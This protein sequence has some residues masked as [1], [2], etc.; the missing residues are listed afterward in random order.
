[1]FLAVGLTVYRSL[2]VMCGEGAW[3]NE[4]SNLGWE[5]NTNDILLNPL[6]DLGNPS[7]VSELERD[8]RDGFYRG[9]RVATWCT[10]FSRC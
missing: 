7:L 2:E 8:L 5:S 6:D 10:T 9:F 3:S 4:M 1:M